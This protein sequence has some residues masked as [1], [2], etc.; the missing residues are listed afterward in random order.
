MG[1]LVSQHLAPFT[2]LEDQVKGREL[3]L[4]VESANTPPSVIGSIYLPPAG[5][6]ATQF[7]VLK[8]KVKKLQRVFS[9]VLISGD[10]NAESRRLWQHCGAKGIDR[11]AVLDKRRTSRRLDKFC[12]KLN[13]RLGQRTGW[14]ATRRNSKGDLVSAI[15][16]TL[17]SAHTLASH[18]FRVKVGDSLASDH[19][20]VLCRTRSS[21]AAVLGI[22]RENIREDEEQVARTPDSERLPFPRID[23]RRKSSYVTK[24]LYDNA[25]KFRL[26]GELPTWAEWLKCAKS[27]VGLTSAK[28]VATFRKKVQKLEPPE[29]LNARRSRLREYSKL[30]RLHLIHAKKPHLV[31]PREI[32]SAERKYRELRKICA[33]LQKKAARSD[34]QKQLETLLADPKNIWVKA[35]ELGFLPNQVSQTP[36]AIVKDGQLCFGQTATE[37]LRD[38]FAALATKP[39]N[40]DYT[41]E[42]ERLASL[43]V[44]QTLRTHN[45]PSLLTGVDPDEVLDAIRSLPPRK[46]VGMDGVPYELF[47]ALTQPLETEIRSEDASGDVNEVLSSLI[48]VF[49][50]IF[51]TQQIP[52]TW[53]LSLLSPLHKK[54]SRTDPSN[55]RGLALFS[56]SFKLLQR[57]FTKRLVNRLEHLNYFMPEQRG[58]RK[59]AECLEQLFCL[60]E[61]GGI[62]KHCGKH[63]FV[64]FVDLYKAYDCVPHNLMFQKLRLAGFTED[65]VQYVRNCYTNHKCLVKDE[66][67]VSTSFPYEQGL[68]QGQVESPIFFD[69]FNNDILEEASE[70]GLGVNI[71][72][73][74]P[75]PAHTG[76]AARTTLTGLVI[77]DELVGI[78]ESPTQLQLLANTLSNWADRSGLQ[79]N[80]RKCGWMDLSGSDTTFSLTLA[81]EAIQ[82]VDSYTYLGVPFAPNLDFRN[83]LAERI[84]KTQAAVAAVY[85]ML[86]HNNKLPTLLKVKV[87]KTFIIPV[88]L[89][90]CEIWCTNQS[91]IQPLQRVVDRALAKALDI[92]MGET[93][94]FVIRCETG[95]ESLYTMIRKR[96]ARALRKWME[97]KTWV[98]ACIRAAST[99]GKKVGI[100]ERINSWFKTHLSIDLF[101]PATTLTN[102]FTRLEEAEWK[103]A[104]T[105]VRFRS[106][107]LDWYVRGGFGTPTKRMFNPFSGISSRG[108]KVLREMRTH[109][110]LTIPRLK[111]SRRVSNLLFGCLC[112]VDGVDEDVP[113]LLLECQTWREFRPNWEALIVDRSG[114]L[115]QQYVGCGRTER[116]ILLLGGKWRCSREVKQRVYSKVLDY[117]DT[118][119]RIR[120]ERLSRVDPDVGRWLNSYGAS[121]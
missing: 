47:R 45:Q 27:S 115:N 99:Q 70:Q 80:P 65:E 83:A 100:I 8:R 29:V 106:V 117:L 20:P 12:S 49:N 113:H 40:Q 64:L 61:V 56:N 26:L 114:R 94:T 53:R 52:D 71:P 88:A 95:T 79:L 73:L 36:T 4:K 121:S 46:A 76:G 112:E 110:F 84:A 5:Q 103:Q 111:G 32:N 51:V 116:A 6:R 68:L 75:P 60:T 31:T 120:K 105:T 109:A 7:R 10:F 91:V 92:S 58:F 44:P 93:S 90:G 66:D 16:Y 57:V 86:A 19:L 1:I 11:L 89:Y 77:A 81:G 48:G 67:R 22:D 35:K 82:K 23:W 15:D 41:A 14:P 104:T 37:A 33:R 119:D 63:T 50:N 42:E 87:I 54:G 13:L 28:R 96:Q 39:P 101:A 78:S 2:H 85:P 17:F 25:R 3:W 97:S 62:R 9:R 118:L 69:I 38:H 30:K 102:V 18:T 107:G 98:G 59:G 43:E 72:N 55:Y 21:T 108:E 74:V 34:R 24:K